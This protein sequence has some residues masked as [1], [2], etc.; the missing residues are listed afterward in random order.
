MK[1]LRGTR[2][3]SIVLLSAIAFIGC[4]QASS[5]GKVDPEPLVAA[6][7]TASPGTKAIVDKVVAALKSE[8]YE[9]ADRLL[10]K[11]K[12]QAAQAEQRQAIENLLEAM[13]PHPRTEP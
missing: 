8:E 11:L 12:K 2:A 3:L 7:K 6:F 5:K 10:Q 4:Q 13:P 1:C 9:S